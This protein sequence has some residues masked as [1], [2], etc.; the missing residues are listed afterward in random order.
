VLISVSYLALIGRCHNTTIL[1]VCGHDDRR[2]I[3]NFEGDDVAGESCQRQASKEMNN[4][5][6]ALGSCL[7][8]RAMLRPSIFSGRHSRECW[9]SMGLM[10]EDEG[11]VLEARWGA[12]PVESEDVNPLTECLRGQARS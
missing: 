11:G 5:F 2:Q 4:H 8:V 10:Q 9:L 7:G 6:P 1:F 12:N 3:E